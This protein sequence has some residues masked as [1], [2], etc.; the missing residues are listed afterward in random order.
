MTLLARLLALLVLSLTVARADEPRPT[1]ADVALALVRVE[2]ALAGA[3]PDAAGVAD[4]NRRFDRATIAFFSGDRVGALRQ[5]DALTLRLLGLEADASARAAI[6]LRVRLDP[7]RGTAGAPVVVRLDPLYSVD[8]P[9]PT[10]PVSLR[11]GGAGGVLVEVPAARLAAGSGEPLSLPGAL[12]PGLHLVTLAL[13]DAGPTLDAGRVAV[14]ERDLDAARDA[15]GRRLAAL[16]DDGAGGLPCAKARL[17]LL[18]SRPD[19]EDTADALADPVALLAELE[20]ETAAL[21]AGR[22]P[23]RGRPGEQWR[24]FPLGEQ[25]VRYRLLAPEAAVARG[26]RLPVLVAFHGFEGDENMFRFAYGRGRLFELAAER[27]LLLVT[28]RTEPFLRSPAAFERLLDT[29]ADDYPID[30]GRLFVLGHSMGAQA[31]GLV[32]R[33]HGAKLAGVALFAGQPVGDVPT[34][35]WVGSLDPLGA[36]S[37]RG[38]DGVTVMDGAGHT[39]GVGPALGEAVEWLQGLAPRR[40]YY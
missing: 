21:E 18:R 37:R 32:A 40:V 29:L 9:A 24:A 12:A 17:R 19:E 10:R 39:L 34:R 25:E 23:Y 8:G 14:V 31:A 15:L 13:G 27:G 28:P 36:F 5:L 11:I 35:A 33:R 7:P 3:R 38:G 26:G 20:L 1:R 16:V 22:D 4:A 6:R 2:E 30:R